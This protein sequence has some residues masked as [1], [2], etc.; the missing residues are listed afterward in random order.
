MCK[1]LSLFV[2]PFTIFIFLYFTL[3]WD[4]MERNWLC[5]E[6]AH[7]DIIKFTYL[8]LQSGRSSFCLCAEPW[9]HMAAINP[10]MKWN[11]ISWAR[12][13]DNTVSFLLAESM[14]RMHHKNY[15]NNLLDES[16][17]CKTEA[18]W[19]G[20]NTGLRGLHNWKLS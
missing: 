4:D 2:L 17:T 14:V 18:H 19:R 3:P 9:N 5:L 10:A 12:Q 13:C 7:V 16:S 8:I 11:M 15:M 1:L 20:E 6:Y